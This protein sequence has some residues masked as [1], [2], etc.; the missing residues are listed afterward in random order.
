MNE[1]YIGKSDVSFVEED[2]QK[3]KT[4]S[5]LT[6]DTSI[7]NSIANTESIVNTDKEKNAKDNS[8]FNFMNNLQINPVIEEVCNYSSPDFEEIGGSQIAKSVVNNV[9]DKVNNKVDGSIVSDK[10]EKKQDVLE[11]EDLGTS[12]LAE[13]KTYNMDMGNN[14]NVKE[15]EIELEKE[16]EIELEKQKQIELEKEKEIE[17]EKQKQI[18]LE[19]Q[20]QIELEKEKQIELEKQKQIELEKQKQIEIEKEKQKQMQQSQNNINDK[21]PEVK[22]QVNTNTKISTSPKKETINIDKNIPVEEN[23]PLLVVADDKSASNNNTEES[24]QNQN[25][26]ND[27][28]TSIFTTIYNQLPSATLIIGGLLVGY[29]AFRKFR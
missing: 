25:Q 23:E 8:K 20:K 29:M 2:L 11:D 19:K 5:S 3:G 13:S 17:L 14:E 16:K 27:K 4:E 12:S 1:S 10:N 24:A 15:K 28:A 21:I 9:N 18:E 6:E 26:E 7:M 22:E